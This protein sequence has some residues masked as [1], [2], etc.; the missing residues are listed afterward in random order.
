MHNRRAGIHLGTS[1]NYFNRW[2]RG[3]SPTNISLTNLH[4][5]LIA[6]VRAR[7]SQ[8]VSIPACQSAHVCTIWNPRIW[9]FL[10][11][12]SVERISLLVFPPLQ[13]CGV[14]PV[15]PLQASRLIILMFH[16]HP[17]DNACV[18]ARIWQFKVRIYKSSSM[19]V[20]YIFQ[21]C[22][23]KSGE[24]LLITKVVSVFLDPSIRVRTAVQLDASYWM[25]WQCLLYY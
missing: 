25:Y 9:E 11:W 16:H 1:V 12:A 8:R 13:A 22:H 19:V 7:F 21:L 3:M 18:H 4:K 14:S 5:L 10:G 15:P 2:F 20:L 6:N 17:R 23:H 24:C